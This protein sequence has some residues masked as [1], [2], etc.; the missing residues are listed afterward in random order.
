MSHFAKPK[1]I[2]FLITCLRDVEWSMRNL[3]PHTCA[4]VLTGE[5][6]TNKKYLTMDED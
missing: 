1:N 5:W 3:M 2:K 4:M 6:M